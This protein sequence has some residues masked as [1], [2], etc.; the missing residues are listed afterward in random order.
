MTKM[1]E[2]V[3]MLASFEK[4]VGGA[5]RSWARF[6]RRGCHAQE[7]CRPRSYAGPG[8]MPDLLH[9]LLPAT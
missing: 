1:K 8:A 4:T 9:S 6:T 7:L 2:S 3:L 5:L